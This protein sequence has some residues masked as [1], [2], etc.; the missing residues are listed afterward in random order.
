MKN[1]N[2]DIKKSINQQTA[3]NYQERV[4]QQS[5]T[6][7]RVFEDDHYYLTLKTDQLGRIVGLTPQFDFC[8]NMLF[9]SY[10]NSA[11]MRVFTHDHGS[12]AVLAKNF[13]PCSSTKSPNAVFMQQMLGLVVDETRYIKHTQCSLDDSMDSCERLMPCRR[14]WVDGVALHEFLGEQKRFLSWCEQIADFVEHSKSSR[15]RHTSISAAWRGIAGRGRDKVSKHPFRGNTPLAFKI[16]LSSP[17]A[18]G[19]ALRNKIMDLANAD[20]YQVSVRVGGLS[21]F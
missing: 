21:V 18:R 15:Y 4:H 7:R 10:G 6:P 5:Y 17:S 16:C 9:C 3:S 11:G 20:D 1:N 14:G 13:I 8:N 12:L 2:Q 19:D